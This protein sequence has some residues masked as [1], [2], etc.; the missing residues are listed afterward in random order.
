MWL[1]YVWTVHSIYFITPS[2]RSFQYEFIT[3]HK[4]PYDNKTMQGAVHLC[5]ENDVFVVYLKE[6]NVALPLP[7]GHYCSLN[8]LCVLCLRNI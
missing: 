6:N 8:V 5:S 1:Y 4:I 7:N 2:Y 3:Q